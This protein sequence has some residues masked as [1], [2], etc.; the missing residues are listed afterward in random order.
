VQLDSV[1]DRHHLY[2]RVHFI[3]IRV[4]DP[5][6]RGSVCVDGSGKLAARRRSTVTSE[7]TMSIME[8]V[9]AFKTT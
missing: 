7:H 9:H 1:S 4:S 8:Y 5:A 2:D 3:T 6:R